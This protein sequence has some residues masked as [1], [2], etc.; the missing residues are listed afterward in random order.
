[1]TQLSEEDKRFLKSW[2]VTFHPFPVRLS[3]LT[4]VDGFH[5]VE[6]IYVARLEPKECWVERQKTEMRSSMREFEIE[7]DDERWYITEESND[8]V[9]LM[10]LYRKSFGQR[11]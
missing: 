10:P 3:T 5:V 9:W 6:T 1:M 7:V 11:G 4:I 2:A 8:P